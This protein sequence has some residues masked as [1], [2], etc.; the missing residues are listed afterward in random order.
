VAENIIP[1]GTM[2][3]SFIDMWNAMRRI[4]TVN[5]L[6]AS[7]RHMHYKNI[8][9]PEFSDMDRILGCEPLCQ[10][11]DQLFR[12]PVYLDKPGKINGAF[13]IWGNKGRRLVMC[14]LLFIVFCG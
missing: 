4:F 5:T 3:P 9:L 6:T 8:V 1:E 13:K 2:K 7:D 11:L 12:M 10:V 14:L